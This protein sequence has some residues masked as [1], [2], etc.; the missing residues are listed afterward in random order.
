[1]VKGGYHGYSAGKQMASCKCCTVANAQGL[2]LVVL[3]QAANVQDSVGAILVLATAKA[4]APQLHAVALG[5]WTLPE[6]VV[7][8][9]AG[10]AREVVRAPPGT[11]GFVVLLR[12]M[13]VERRF[14]WLSK[15]RRVTGRYYKIKPHV[16]K[17]IVKACFCHLMLRRLAKEP[18]P[19][20]ND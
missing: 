1:V 19:R 4:N 17:V 16:S 6:A 14:G 11:K 15:Y 10:P 3:V 7:D 20:H 9:S 8:H 12:S 13:V 2:F 5:L 18:P